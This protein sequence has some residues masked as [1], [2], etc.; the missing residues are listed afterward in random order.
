MR[1]MAT[2]LTG[3]EVDDDCDGAT[4]DGVNDD[5]KC[6]MG[7]EVDNAVYLR[8]VRVAAAPRPKDSNGNECV[9]GCRR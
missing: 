2:D 1:K 4:G 8:G 5:G 6:A 3:D 7:D 9:D